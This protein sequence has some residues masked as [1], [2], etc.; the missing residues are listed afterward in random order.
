MSIEM[1]ATTLVDDYRSMVS[2]LHTSVFCW[3][4]FFQFGSLVACC[5]DYIVLLGSGIDFSSNPVRVTFNPGEIHKTTSIPVIC[6]RVIERVEVFN[7]RL[8]V[9]SAPPD[10]TIDLGLSNCIGVIMDSTGQCCHC[11]F[12]GK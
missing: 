7:M 3:F 1:V 11:I 6:D 9:V 8:S 12:N 5:N 10:I 2:C 4:F